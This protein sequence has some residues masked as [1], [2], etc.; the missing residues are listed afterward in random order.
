MQS[1]L[2]ICVFGGLLSPIYEETTVKQKTTLDDRN[3]QTNY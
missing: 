1:G 3:K 2:A